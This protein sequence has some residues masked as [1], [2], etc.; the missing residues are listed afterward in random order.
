MAEICKVSCHR[1]NDVHGN[2]M[3]K[4]RYLESLQWLK[5]QVLEGQGEPSKF[6]VLQ[7]N[8]NNAEPN[9]YAIIE[10][11]DVVPEG[12]SLFHWQKD[13]LRKLRPLI[14]EWSR[15][16]GEGLALNV[17]ST[18]FMEHS[19]LVELVLRDLMQLPS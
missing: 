1:S 6:V 11:Q 13:F 8:P 14:N 10:S 16:R 7:A 9:M 12:T 2:G 18:D 17:I 4:V 15:N 5:K 19:E 3:F